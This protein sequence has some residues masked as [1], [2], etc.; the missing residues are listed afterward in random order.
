MTI[1]SFVVSLVAVCGAIWAALNGRR[2]AKAAESQ[3]ELLREQVTDER[4]RFDEQFRRQSEQTLEDRRRG[5][6]AEL[7]TDLRRFTPCPTSEE[8]FAAA[9][10]RV[11]VAFWKW[12][13]LVPSE[14]LKSTDGV[15]HLIG[16]LID[17]AKAGIGVERNAAQE[18][19]QQLPATISIEEVE[20][21]V[22]DLTRSGDDWHRDGKSGERV[23]AWFIQLANGE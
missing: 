11:L 21:R 12:R 14:K 22:Y 16:V 17:A 4:A 8:E 10:H 5:A 18:S 9:E 13:L 15:Y 20:S 19:G 2:E 3:V 1:A 6:W 23:D 7:I